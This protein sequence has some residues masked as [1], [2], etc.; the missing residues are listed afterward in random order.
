MSLFVYSLIAGLTVGL[1]FLL[2]SFVGKRKD[3]LLDDYT[4]EDAPD[5]VRIIEREVHKFIEKEI[6][7]EVEKIVIDTEEIDNLTTQK[8]DLSKKIENQEKELTIK[9]SELETR[10]NALKTLKD[11]VKKLSDEKKELEV[12][13]IE[14]KD[15]LNSLSEEL[16]DKQEMY[17]NEIDELAKSKELDTKE[18]QNIITEKE[19][20][21][22]K[23]SINIDKLKGEISD[24]KNKLS[25]VD[26]NRK[27][28][29]DLFKK[30]KKDLDTNKSD[31]E[32]FAKLIDK[33]DQEISELKY[34]LD[35][36]TIKHPVLYEGTDDY[37]KFY[38]VY[39]LPKKISV[40]RQ[41]KIQDI[42]AKL[43]A[44]EFGYYVVNTTNSYETI[45]VLNINE[46]TKTIKTFSEI[47]NINSK[48]NIFVIIDSRAYLYEIY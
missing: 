34:K 35:N 15:K 25:E 3:Y 24:V 32:H 12:S 7:K 13:H 23:A 8:E 28:Y 27:E 20:L 43:K 31:T 33:K 5:N 21:L 26:K 48:Y 38:D 4:D 42:S 30:A 17:E 1:F 36:I 37:G 18:Q 14:L 9:L 45:Q 39:S 10:E 40:E 2:I 44:D 29:Q 6:I 22:N 11:K 19:A 16:A 47:D 46:L 41:H